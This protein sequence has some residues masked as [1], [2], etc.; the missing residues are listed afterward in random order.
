[1]H[2]GGRSYTVGE[3]ASLAHVSVRTRHERVQPGLATFIRDAIR[4]RAGR[5][6][7]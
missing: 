5:P 1:M 6:A 7:A 2:E 4:I 3:L